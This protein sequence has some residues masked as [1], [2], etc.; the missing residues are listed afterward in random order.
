MRLAPCPP[1]QVPLGVGADGKAQA[2][3]VGVDA[4][5]G[6]HPAQLGLL[7]DLLPQQGLP[8]Q[9]GVPSGP[10]EG[11]ARAALD[12]EGAALA[13]ALLHRRVPASV[14]RLDRRTAL[15]YARVTSRQ[16]LPTQP[17]PARVATVL[18]GSGVDQ[19]SSWTTAEVVWAQA[20]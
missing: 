9:A 12:A 4:G 17:S 18:W 5:G 19:P 1:P 14:T 10:G 8:G 13:L 16:L 20:R 6:L 2:A 7:A 11:L 3:Q 15:P